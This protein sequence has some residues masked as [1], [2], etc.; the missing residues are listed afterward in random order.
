M[1]KGTNLD[2]NR[3][4]VIKWYNKVRTPIETTYK[5]NQIIPHFHTIKKLV[6]QIIHLY[7]N[8]ANIHTILTPQEDNEQRRLPLAINY[9]VITR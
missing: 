1:A 4:I 8:N 5:D 6:I 7:P 3:R 2:V 9:L